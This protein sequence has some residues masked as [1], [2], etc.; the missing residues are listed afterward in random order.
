MKSVNVFTWTL[1]IAFLCGCASE[2][3]KRAEFYMPNQ[4]A[5][6]GSSRKKNAPAAPFSRAEAETAIC[7]AVVLRFAHDASVQLKT[8]PG[9]VFVELTPNKLDPDP[10]FLGRFASTKFRVAPIS[11][12]ARSEDNRLIEK[13]TGKPGVSL[14][15]E[16]VDW[17][18]R[19]NVEVPFAWSV[20]A[21]NELVFFYRLA[22]KKGKWIVL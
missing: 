7:E 5:I 19:Y 3:R 21:D 20:G 12:A 9:T 11:A 2:A 18:D 13:Q 22:W 17:L 15:I 1:L 10:E 14:R 4:P 8:A 16:R 6:T